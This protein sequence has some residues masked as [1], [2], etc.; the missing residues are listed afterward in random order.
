[1]KRSCCFYV[2]MYI[3]LLY[4]SFAF[5]D[6]QFES[7]N[8]NFVI[9][10]L[11]SGKIQYYKKRLYLDRKENALEKI[12]TLVFSTNCFYEKAV[13][14]ST[15]EEIFNKNGESGWQVVE[16][17]MTTYRWSS[18]QWWVG[19]SDTIG[20]GWMIRTPS[21]RSDARELMADCFFSI[22]A[23]HSGQS[24]KDYDII[25]CDTN[26]KTLTYTLGV[27]SNLISKHIYNYDSRLE[28]YL[29]R[30]K[31]LIDKETTDVIQ[32]YQWTGWQEYNGICFATES[33]HVTKENVMWLN[34]KMNRL[35]TSLESVCD[36]YILL[37]VEDINQNFNR[38]WFIPQFP[39]APVAIA[40]RQSD[41]IT[42]IEQN[43][44]EL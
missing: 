4:Q 24:G 22:S 18:P 26:D 10:K 29:P 5:T 25:N 13:F 33:K 40:D 11:H 19:G 14:N 28:R 17:N 42:I 43:N 44:D 8:S 37:I 41:E 1:M 34:S 15:V 7:I 23:L 39:K 3:L 16:T 2:C 30:E 36:E 31:M 20:T 27:S 12:V 21:D 9:D 6:T 32:Y 35:D 38:R